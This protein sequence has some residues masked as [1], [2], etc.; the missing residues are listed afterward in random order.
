MKQPL[1]VL[2]R[3]RNTPNLEAIVPRL[4][5]EILHR[6]VQHCG[7]QDSVELV[8]LATPEQISRVLDVDVWRVPAA[9]LNEEFDLDRFGLWLEVLL[10]AG[11]AVAAEKLAGLDIDVVIAGFAGHTEVFDAAVV[12]PYTMLDGQ[13][14]PGRVLN[15]GAVAEVGGYVLQ[16]RRTPGWD[17][18]VESLESLATADPQFFHRLMRGCMDLSDGPREADGCDSLLQDDEQNLFDLA[19]DREARREK[20]GYL[21]PAQARA[22]LQAA[23]ELRLDGGPPP[24]SP[25]ARAYFRDI[26]STSRPVGEAPGKSAGLL[27]ESG[28]D[29]VT[30]LEADAVAGVVELLRE[31]G[32]L[33]P[34]PRGLLG[35]TDARSARLALIEAHVESHQG[36]AEELAY[37]ANSVISGCS[38]HGRAFTVQEASDA[39][40]AVC[41]LGLENWPDDWRERN[42]ISAFQVGW[43]VLHRN[44]GMFAAQRLVEITSDIPARTRHIQLRLAGLRRALKQ[45]LRDRAPWRAGDDLDVILM[46]DASSWAGLTGL[47]GECPVLH[48]SIADTARRSGHTIKPEDFEFIA[49]NSQIEAI[50]AFVESLPSAL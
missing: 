10:Q 48:A 13:E 50:H 49:R 6:L 7:L 9:G 29:P 23:R 26:D 44:V 42:L 4:P 47:F 41:N 16:A 34:P 40:V 45:H 2:E 43:S 22:F 14:V 18:V 39:A 5:P 8:A 35:A 38:I 21:A 33:T 46:L 19:S 12:A 3:L 24:G 17:A 20:Q 25:I 37:L 28:G 1:P 15:Q 36:C 32:V 27:P 30:E 31:A 11:G